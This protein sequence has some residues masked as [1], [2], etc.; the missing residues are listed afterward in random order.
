MTV[1]KNDETRIDL[2]LVSRISKRGPIP[3]A[4]R[5]F[6]N[7]GECVSELAPYPAD[8]SQKLKETSLKM[9]EFNFECGDHERRIRERLDYKYSTN[10]MG[11]IDRSTNAEELGTT[12]ERTIKI[13]SNRL[14]AVTLDER[15]GRQDI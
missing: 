13:H 15:I 11:N 9:R 6:V 7:V 3:E 10:G 4:F 5:S 8:F 14:K 2:E 12:T 1:K